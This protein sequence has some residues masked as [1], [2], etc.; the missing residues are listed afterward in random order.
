MK[1]VT[2]RWIIIFSGISLIGLIVTQLF[3]ITNAVKLGEQQFDSRV[4]IALQGSLDQYLQMHRG[5]DCDVTCGCLSVSASPDSLFVNLDPAEL[6]SIMK[7][8]FGYHGL[9]TLFVFRVILCATGD[10]VFEKNENLS[11]RKSVGCHR[12]SLSCLHHEESHHLEV[13]FSNT[14]NWV[15]LDLIVWLGASTLFLVTVIL[16]F[17]FIVFS[18]I[19]QKKIT[20]IRN[21]FINNMTHEFKTPVS[22]IS[23]ACEILHRPEIQKDPGRVVKYIKIVT[24]ENQRMRKQVDRVLQFSVRNHE[25]LTLKKELSDIH[26]IIRDAVEHVCMND[27]QPGAEVRF[28]LKAED[29][30]IMIDPVHFSNIIHNLLDNAQ[31]YCKT[32]PEISIKTQSTGR[33]LII[34]FSDNGP[35]ISQEAQ[36]RVFEKF[37]R[38][39]TGDLYNTKGF[40]LGLYYVKTMVLAHGGSIKVVSEPGKGARFIITIPKGI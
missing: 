8:H 12:I 40:G 5:R 7:V 10:V 24:E 32:D 37:Y 38:V 36:K 11:K 17:A 6:D 30:V 9:D 31:K 39:P 35:G 4:A 15:L 19:R 26:E 2:I 34:D 33:Q 14:R 3:W 21:D 23:L 16:T 1:R 25:D 20:D 13:C 28:D 29:P 27:C 22:N 18:I